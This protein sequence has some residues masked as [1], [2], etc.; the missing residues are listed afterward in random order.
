MAR[1]R[2]VPRGFVPLEWAYV[3]RYGM[4]GDDSGWEVPLDPTDLGEV[5]R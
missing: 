2:G 5:H 4:R 1:W 3:A